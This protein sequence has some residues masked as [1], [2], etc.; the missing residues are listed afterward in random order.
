MID[1][2]NENLI[3]LRA[4]CKLPP[5]RGREGKAA[6][7]SS[8]Y[9]HALRGAKASDGSRIKLETVRT[10]SGLKTSTEA[11][12]RFIAA[13]TG[14]DVSTTYSRTSR[15]READIRRAEAELAASGI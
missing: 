9:R 15:H 2:L 5:F 13:L 3:D 4:A 11:V 10:P 12:S 8:L 6:H 14:D 7:I 1:V